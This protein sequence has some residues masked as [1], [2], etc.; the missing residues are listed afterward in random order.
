MKHPDVMA[1][2]TWLA[3]KE[4]QSSSADNGEAYGKYLINRLHYAFFAGR[5]TM[6]TEYRAELAAKVRGMK[7]P[8]GCYEHTDS[9]AIH[10][11]T[12]DQVLK[13]LES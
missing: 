6:L 13:I 9:P 1:W 3:S 12:I 7:Q 11:A 5:E 8:D 10:N 4:G 2:E